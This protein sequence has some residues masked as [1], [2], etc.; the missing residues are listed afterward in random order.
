MAGRKRAGKGLVPSIFDPIGK[1]DQNRP[2]GCLEQLEG[3]HQHFSLKFRIAGLA[4]RT[5]HRELAME[6]ARGMQPFDLASNEREGHGGQAPLFQ[7]VGER[8]DGTRA[9]GSD[10]RQEND[11]YAVLQQTASPR[12]DRCPGAAS[13]SFLHGAT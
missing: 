4:E 5:A 3:R 13:P 11:V 8:T 2:L 12:R 6:G 9:Q 1:I 10:G 7:D